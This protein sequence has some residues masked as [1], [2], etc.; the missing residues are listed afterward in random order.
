MNFV[1]RFVFPVKIS[2]LKQAVSGS[3]SNTIAVRR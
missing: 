2:T 1:I 3:G